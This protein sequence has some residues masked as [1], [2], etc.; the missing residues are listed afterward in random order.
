M[1]LPGTG[2]W[3]GSQEARCCGAVQNAWEEESTAALLAQCVPQDLGPAWRN[4]ASLVLPYPKYRYSWTTEEAGRRTLSSFENEEVNKSPKQNFYMPSLP[5]APHQLSGCPAD[6]RW[7]WASLM[8]YIYKQSSLCC[9]WYLGGS[10]LY[11]SA[12]SNRRQSF[13]KATRNLIQ[14]RIQVGLVRDCIRRYTAS[15]PSLWERGCMEESENSLAFSSGK[16]ILNSVAAVSFNL[17]A[18]LSLLLLQTASS[19]HL[20][21]ESSFL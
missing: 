1:L 9:Y 15:V 19:L 17:P 2:C 3:E 8:A 7:Q 4:A 12:D 18:D 16:I 5:A 6:S 20:Q 11:T 21:K 10:F 14:C 13:S